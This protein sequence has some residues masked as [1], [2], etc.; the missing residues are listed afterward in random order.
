MWQGRRWIIAAVLLFSFGALAGY[1]TAAADPETVLEQMQPVIDRIGVLGQRVVASPSP[2]ERTWII[3]RNNAQAISVMVIGGIFFGVVPVLGMIGNGALAG[4]VIALSGRL[5]PQAADPWQ[6]F[7]ALAPH[8]VL[9]LPALWLGAAWAMKL[10]LAWV[11]PPPGMGRLEVFK[12]TAREAVIV[13]AIVM[14]LLLIA[15]IIEANL[16][17]A[18]VERARAS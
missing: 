1:A 16:T 6:I 10:G 18:L 9:E 2:V 7:V 15:A 8:A 12:N 3:Y 5:A 4:I 13:L 11:V 17:L 14:V